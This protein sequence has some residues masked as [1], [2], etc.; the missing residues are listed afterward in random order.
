MEDNGA[1]A[2]RVGSGIPGSPGRRRIGPWVEAMAGVAILVV[3]LRRLGTDSVLVAV[4][5][6]TVP[7]LAAAAA[8]GL[9]TTVCCSWRWRLV[10]RGLGVRLPLR[11]A[12]AAYYRSLF[13]NVTLPGGVLG[14]VHRAVNHGRDVGDV[15]RGV[16]AVAWERSA[17]Q[18][19][20]LALAVA[21]MLFV[22]SPARA[23]APVVLAALVGLVLAG[24]I[25]GRVRRRGRPTAGSRVGRL[26]AVVG[27]DLRAGVLSRRAWPGIVLA[28]TVVV[29]GHAATFVI[30]A[31]TAGSTVSPVRM[32]PLAVVVLLAMGI[33]ASIA[34]W[35][36][37]EAVAA[38]TSGLA[39]LSA[40][41]AV[42][43]AVVYGVLVLAASLPGAVLIL[44]GR[45][46]RRPAGTGGVR[47]V[48]PGTPVVAALAAGGG[49]E[50]G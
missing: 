8:I 7:S 37:R 48:H 32:L 2:G 10:A 29:V 4:R 9:V 45:L 28:S 26:I 34:G 21:V 49:A 36:P 13:L 42:S 3:L 20:Q 39:G 31:R 46:H 25:L 11:V 5:S 14:D 43:T 17:G 33:P 6:I 30:A 41:D 40:A 35:G 15:G 38:S 44:A 27:A 22:P 50:H 12:V 19:V 23:L 47:P 18:A 16:R 1:V 24:A